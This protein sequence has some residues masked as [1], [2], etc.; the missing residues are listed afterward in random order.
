MTVAQPRPD[1]VPSRSDAPLRGR[2]L[3]IV[4]WIIAWLGAQAV[5]PLLSVGG[6]EVTDVPGLLLQ[7]A[8]AALIWVLLVLRYPDDSGTLTAVSRTVWMYAMVPVAA[9][10]YVIHLGSAGGLLY[11]MFIGAFGIGWRWFLF[12]ILQLRLATVVPRAAVLWVSAAGMGTWLTF[13]GSSTIGAAQLVQW[14]ILILVSLIPAFL[15]IALKNIHAFVAVGL[16]VSL[17][18]A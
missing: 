11:D 13:A 18:M 12:G 16:T 2:N 6:E 8:V 3:R 17:V 15:R 9:C 1:S 7:G 14:P 5:T 10:V 4:A